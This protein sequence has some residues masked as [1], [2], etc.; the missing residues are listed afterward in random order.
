M[1]RKSKYASPV[2]GTPDVRPHC[3]AAIYLR[4]S[5]EDGD[6]LESNSIGNQRKICL[7]YLEKHSDFEIGA[8]YVDDGC[9]GMNY[10]RPGFQSM[11]TDLKAK[12][13]NCVIVKDISR[14]GRH[15]IMTSEYVEKVFPEMGIRLI[16]IN[17]D[18]DS[19]DA[20]SD[21]D[22]LLMPFK[23]VMNDTYVKDTAR[24]IQ[25]SIHAKMDS[26]EYLPSSG[27]V[28]Y[29][30]QRAPEKG[31]FE[32][33]RET[34]PVVQRIFEMRAEGMMF[35]TIA[36]TLND[37]GIPSPG[38]LRFDRGL[39]KSEKYKD[40][41]WLRGTIRKLTGDAVYTGSRIHGKIARERLGG[42]KKAQPK[43]MWQVI[44]D[45]HPP[46]ITQV[47]FDQVQEINRAE[48]ERQAAYDT[49]GNPDPDYRRIFRGKVFCGECGARMTAGIVTGR[50]TAPVS[51]YFN[52]NQYRY[53]NHRRCS[54]HYVRQELLLDTL[55]H[56]LDKQV[57]IAVNV[58]RLTAEIRK[59][60]STPASTQNRLASLR[61]QR[62][63]LESKENRLLED[64][65]TGILD[66]EEYVRIKSRYRSEHSLLEQQEQN[67]SKEFERIKSALG[68]AE[69]WL[70]A[71][72]RYREIPRIDRKIVDVLVDHILVFEDRSIRISMTY[73][74][75]FALLEA[76]LDSDAGG[77]G[78]V[79]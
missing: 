15:Y 75:P 49:R 68:T 14:L 38:K 10:K 76:C 61:S 22:G 53:S 9:T 44:P 33:D 1:A 71:I 59:L 60:E 65:A 40:A 72:R 17:D 47:L 52:C 27:S 48:L 56:F 19:E 64:L 16:C 62:M 34:A 31:S 8:F 12:K 54:N 55:K 26:G 37:E 50:K 21:R 57:E 23:L 42:G 6:S 73:G 58:E 63:N 30:Y 77:A 11:F 35:N 18:Y 78:H 51:V 39:M 41:L 46:I 20:H 74:N 5:V 4:L 79:E 67:A 32:I 13:A 2:Q 24:R 69:T 66:R 43:E 29:G 25:S 7:A 45:A 36:K 28:P 3:T 70:S